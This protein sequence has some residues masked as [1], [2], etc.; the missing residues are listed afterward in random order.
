[1]AIGIPPFIV[2]CYYITKEKELQWRPISCIICAGRD[3]H[4]NDGVGPEG[5]G[6][7]R[8]F[9]SKTEAKGPGSQSGLYFF[10]KFTKLIIA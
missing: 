7:F 5:Q 1:L 9:D 8:E 10:V 3:E 2:G 6:S 4:A